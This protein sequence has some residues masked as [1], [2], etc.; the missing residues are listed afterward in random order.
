MVFANHFSEKKKP[1][2][3]AKENPEACQILEE[4]L[5][6]LESRIAKRTAQL[7][8]TNQDLKNE[9]KEKLKARDDLLRKEKHLKA[10]QTIAGV[11]SFFALPPDFRM[12]CSDGFFRL[13]GYE[14]AQVPV[15]YSLIK[16][17]I[18]SKDLIRFEKDILHFK[19]FF[20][21]FD[22]E[23]RIVTT[24][25]AIRE[26][27]VIVTTLYNPDKHPQEIRGIVQD[28]TENKAME[29]QVIRNEK[30]ASLG[31]MASGVAHEINNPNSL[32]S[33]NIPILREYLG[34]LFSISDHYALKNKGLEL[35]GMPYDEFKKDVVKLTNNIENGSARINKIVSNFRSFVHVKRNVEYQ[36]TD[37]KA[38]IRGCID[39]SDAK[40][41]KLVRHFEARIPD[42]LPKVH[43]EPE[44]LEIAVINL[45]I[46][47]AQACDK[48]DSHVCLNVEYLNRPKPRL[49]IQVCDNGCGMDKETVS[50]A[51]DPFF[52]TKPSDQGTGIG[53]SLCHNLVSS[54]GGTI[55]VESAPGQGA[56]FKIILPDPK[57]LAEKG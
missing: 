20:S 34:A 19:K 2:A 38:L 6:D 46:N 37:I 26:V 30:L 44:V 41:K 7:E 45:L 12:D 13:L 24:K 53:L 23:Y 14:P 39:I 33:F 35:C 50:R 40:M 28:I 5:S 21:P 10:V 4:A 57:E 11:G 49:V 8:A 22:R 18:H 27:R 32:I 47:A 31:F 43:T 29:R 54:L 17:H 15:D 3:G 56:T 52:S 16:N 55:E 36:K 51:F 42:D 1:A 48:P 25:G 9:V